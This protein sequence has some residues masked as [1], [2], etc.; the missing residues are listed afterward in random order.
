VQPLLSFGAVVPTAA[1]LN[2]KARALLQQVSLPADF[3]RR[4]P[5][6]LSGG[7]RQRVGIARAI[8]L[9]PDLIVADEIVSGLDVS[10]QARIL[11]LLRELRA[12]LGMGMIFVTHDLSVVRVLCDRVVVMREGRVVEEGPTEAVFA[13]PQHPYTRALLDAIPL[14]EID[15]DWLSGKDA[16]AALT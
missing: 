8:A 16:A 3:A 12:R 5:H 15:D 4:Y 2:A 13:R 1:E 11:I 6:E 9:E 7:Q 10:T 14:P